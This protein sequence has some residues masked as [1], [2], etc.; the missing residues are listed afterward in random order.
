MSDTHRATP[1][2]VRQA[3]A[4]HEVVMRQFNATEVRGEGTAGEFHPDGTMQVVCEVT[5]AE[6]MAMR[7][8]WYQEARVR[9]PGIPLEVSY[10]G[11][12]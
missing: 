1:E 6:A 8:A 9:C 10:C 5:V 2:Q 12:L 3:Y 11:I 7:E 4:V